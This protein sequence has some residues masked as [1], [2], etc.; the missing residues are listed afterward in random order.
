VT[1]TAGS[2]LGPYEILSPLGAGGMGEVWRARDTKLGRDVALKVLPPSLAQDAE[3]LQR[4]EREAQVLAS[5]NHPH[6]A[7]IHGV[8]D[9][10][11]IKALVLE[12]VEGPTLQDRIAQGALPA[13]EAIAVARQIADALEAAHEKSIVHRDLKPANVKLT[14]DGNVKVLDFGLA[15]ALDP[16]AGASMSPSTS[17]TLMNSPTL[18]AA[19]TQLGVILGTAA[20]M[21][22]EQARGGAVDKRA[23]IFAFGAVLYEMLTGRRLFEGE[24]VSDILAAVLR[25]EVDWSALPASTPSALRTLLARC[26]EKDRRKRLHDIGDARF[27]LDAALAPA[28]VAPT[29]PRRSRREAAA[30]GLAAAFALALLGTLAWSRPRA[31]PATA[32]TMRLPLTVP[33][34]YTLALDNQVSTAI[35]PDGRR[36]ALAINDKTGRRL[37]LRELDRLEPRVLEGTE[38]ATNPFFS[39]DGQSIGFFAGSQLKKVAVGGGPSVLLTS[40][41]TPQQRGATFCPDGSVV[42]AGAS[43]VGLSRLPANG[44]TPVALTT[45]DRKR[46]E[47]THRWPSPVPGGKAVVFTSD[48]LVSSE[49]YDDARIEAVV[50][51]TG[52]RK[53]LLDGASRA[54]VVGDSLVFAR[55]GSLYAV[56]FDS[57]RLEVHGDPV[58]VLIGVATDGATGAAHFDVSRGGTL[59][60]VPGDS[61]N[62]GTT[63]TWADRTGTESPSGIALGQ[64]SQLALSW[65]GKRAALAGSPGT[66][67]DIWISDLERGTLSRLTFDGIGTDPVWSADGRH[68]AYGFQQAEGLTKVYW[69]A[70]D[71]STEAELLWEGATSALPRSFSPDDKLLLLDI[72]ETGAGSDLWILPLTGDRKPYPFVQSPFDDYMAEISRDGRYLAY[73]SEESGVPEVYVRPFP[74]GAGRWQVSV[75]GG[76]EPRWSPDGRELFYRH[77]GTLF[78]VPIEPGSGFVTGRPERVLDGMFT[79]G[80]PLSYGVAGDG[81]FLRLLRQQS[82]SETGGAALVLNWADEMRGLLHAKAK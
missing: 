36:V 49:Y 70:P 3:R 39:P 10:T 48:T 79:S 41:A 55:G 29:E 60:Y 80:G 14:P 67:S 38:G 45:P 5:L 81:R 52:E 75:G 76:F 73:C 44:G 43:A 15:K 22:P 12:L 34:S 1:I 2:R 72:A 62:S 11:D 16:V 82:A 4:F 57:D 69:K 66:T 59:V 58:V 50:L 28:P 42:F 20:Y 17:P 46:Q 68:V 78:R 19:G 9:S 33:G 32:P 53:V 40:V 65:D 54:M 61:I 13:D 77:L 63:A 26:L 35:S 30:W 64:W 6:I 74:S 51:S 56:P 37:L 7:A 23:D 27:E 47:R 8:E 18:T 21:A 31:A 71:G 24:T 25:A